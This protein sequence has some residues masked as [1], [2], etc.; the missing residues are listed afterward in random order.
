LATHRYVASH[1]A[2]RPTRGQKAANPATKAREATHPCT[3]IHRVSGDARMYRARSPTVTSIGRYTKC[4]S[5]PF[6]QRVA[7]VTAMRHRAPTA[8]TVAV[9]SSTR[10]LGGT[11]EPHKRPART[12]TPRPVA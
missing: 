10:V 11:G 3:R 12:T 9:P 4:G 1:R 6:T 8:A 7:P 5:H 2:E